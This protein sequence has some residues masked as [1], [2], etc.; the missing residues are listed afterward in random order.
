M[1]ILLWTLT[2]SVVRQRYLE[3]VHI[4]CS[5]G[6]RGQRSSSVCLDIHLEL[7]SD[8]VRK[9]FEKLR[10][11]QSSNSPCFYGTGS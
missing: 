3:Q 8:G 9:I 5:D 4:K 11:A 10:V 2:F 7:R 1:G 6:R